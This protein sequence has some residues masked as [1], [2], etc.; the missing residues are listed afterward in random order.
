MP[1]NG[2]HPTLQS[3]RLRATKSMPLSFKQGQMV[4]GRIEKFLPNNK[5]VIQFG[6]QQLIAQLENL[7]QVHKR[8]LF[9]VTKASPYVRL[10]V[11]SE[12]PVRNQK[13][14]ISLLLEK[15]GVKG[16]EN[17]QKLLSILI[18]EQIPIHK[19]SIMKAF[20]LM[21]KAPSF[22]E[23]MSV[24]K[25]MLI[26]KYPMTKEVFDAVY[27]RLFKPISMDKTAVALQTELDHIDTK[28]ARQL[29]HVLS[30]FHQKDASMP[31][32]E[33]LSDQKGI[34]FKLK[35]MLSLLGGNEQLAKFSALNENLT[36]NQSFKELLQL[37]Q[38]Q[39]DKPAVNS[40]I[41]NLQNVVS[42]IQLSLSNQQEW[43]QFSVQFPGEWFGLKEDLFMDFEGKRNEQD[44]I[45]SN[46]CRVMFYLTL[47]NINETVVDLFVQNRSI[48]LSVF[49]DQ[50]EIVKPLT[51][52]LE[53]SLA[54]NLQTLHY[55]L[56]SIVVKDFNHSKQSTSF[57]NISSPSGTEK[58]FDF[59]I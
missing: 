29:Q 10:Q 41:Q 30:L 50:P 48:S 49:N 9:Q 43:S 53:S 36:S 15:M 14:S 5:A 45:D 6:G 58:G 38:A 27:A 17:Q 31:L 21:E 8:Y 42:G 55:Q 20:A 11:M 12:K 57:H 3:I 54:D 46:Y 40:H 22:D 47:Q 56:S 24:I 7:L 44:K 33:G 59:K 18:N 32:L 28:E 16:S 23:G 13:D 1:Q 52:L 2:V 35:V 25:E 26:Q 37:V 39:V 4:T 19:Q 34:L 51:K